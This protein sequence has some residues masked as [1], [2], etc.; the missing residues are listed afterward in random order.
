MRSRGRLHRSVALALACSIAGAAL[1]A[2]TRPGEARI[3]KTRGQGAR[4]PLE[5]TLGSGIEFETDPEESEYGFPFLVEYGLTRI[6]KVTAEPSYVLITKKAGG[7]V[8]GIG[9]LETTITAEFP[10][11]RRNRPALALESVIKWP[12]ARTGDIGTGERDYSL[13]LIVSKEFVN[14]DVD[15]NGVYTF[16]GDPPGVSLKDTFE[17]SL[18]SEWHLNRTFDI[19]AEIVRAIGA[20]GRFR[21]ASLGGFQNIGGPEQGQS[22]TEATLGLAEHLGEFFKLEQGAVVKFDGSFQF[23]IAWEYDF[24]GSR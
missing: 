20:G 16:V 23:V 13:G 1:L 21:G 22:E 9:D 5:L 11:E 17:A 7:N 14:F 24:A 19:E 10:T 2:G 6:L 8:S 4:G 18:A 15:L 12:T 3:L